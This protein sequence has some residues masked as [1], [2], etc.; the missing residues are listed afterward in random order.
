[1]SNKKFVKV[2][3]QIAIL[4]AGITIAG[5]GSRSEGPAQD[6]PRSL[7]VAAIPTEQTTDRQPLKLWQTQA[8]TQL[9]RFPATVEV[10]PEGRLTVWL[11]AVEDYPPASVV[12]GYAQLEGGSTVPLRRCLGDQSLYAQ[13][14]TRFTAPLKITLYTW[15]VEEPYARHVVTLEFQEPNATETKDALDT[16]LELVREKKSQAGLAL[17]PILESICEYSN[18]DAAEDVAARLA[19]AAENPQAPYD[20]DTKHLFREVASLLRRAA[21]TQQTDELLEFLETLR[22]ISTVAP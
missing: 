7:R 14:P 5:C 16:A 19:G 6:Q 18:M 12:R 8:Q 20:G 4:F 13:L 10:N 11:K 17:V 3:Y 22:N 2:F 15:Q 9:G 1:M 21:Q